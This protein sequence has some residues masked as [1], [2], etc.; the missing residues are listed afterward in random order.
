MVSGKAP[1]AFVTEDTELGII[2]SCTAFI[3]SDFLKY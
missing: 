1:D 2:Q 3:L